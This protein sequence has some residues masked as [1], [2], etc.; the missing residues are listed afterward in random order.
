MKDKEWSHNKIY[1]SSVKKN[2]YVQ[3]PTLIEI[4]IYHEYSFSS[5]SK[6]LQISSLSLASPSFTIQVVFTK[7]VQAKQV[8][9]VPASPS[10]LDRYQVRLQEI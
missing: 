10:S 4:F 7:P 6:L 9:F 1:P 2:A 5:F 8:V 3:S